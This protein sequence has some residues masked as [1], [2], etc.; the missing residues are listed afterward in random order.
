MAVELLDGAG[1]LRLAR[2]PQ[3]DLVLAAQLRPHLVERDDVVRVRDRE[4]QALAVLVERDREEVVPLG[5][6]A[7]HD[8][9]CAGIDDDLGEVDGLQPELLATGRRAASPRRRSRAAPAACRPAGGIF[10]CSSSAIR[11]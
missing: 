8:P 6:L 9:D 11:S 2:E 1:D 7:R 5:E 10:S 4:D 3:F